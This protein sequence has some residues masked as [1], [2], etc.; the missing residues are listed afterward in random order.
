MQLP[1]ASTDMSKCAWALVLGSRM[2]RPENFTRNASKSWKLAVVLM[3]LPSS[4]AGKNSL[5][6][7]IL[8]GAKELATSGTT[9]WRKVYKDCNNFVKPVKAACVYCRAAPGKRCSILLIHLPI[10]G[11][12]QASLLAA[13]V[14]MDPPV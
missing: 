6:K 9:Q 1:V 8:T 10:W 11:C 14:P 4:S 13:A 3:A 7:A 2:P 12:N 5:V